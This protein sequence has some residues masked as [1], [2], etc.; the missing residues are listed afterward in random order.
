MAINSK[1]PLRA[2]ARSLAEPATAEPV[3]PARTRLNAAA[4]Q[5]AADR[6]GWVLAPGRAEQIAASALPV[7][8]LFEDVS[9]VIDFDSDPLAF[10]AVRDAVKHREPA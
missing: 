9:K 4:V 1:K 6:V 3:Q 8:D 10:L 5:V 2:G 7:I